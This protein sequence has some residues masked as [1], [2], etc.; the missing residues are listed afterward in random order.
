[1]L[2]LGAAIV[3]SAVTALLVSSASVFADGDPSS[4]GVPKLIPSRARWSRTARP[5]PERST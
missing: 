4:D 3:C 2:T 1:M 5:S